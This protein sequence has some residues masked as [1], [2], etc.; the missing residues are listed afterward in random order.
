ML[1]ELADKRKRY[2]EIFLKSRQDGNKTQEFMA[3]ALGVSRNTIKN[4]ERGTSFPNAFQEELWFEALGLNIDPYKFAYQY[5]ELTDKEYK[6]SKEFVEKLFWKL[7]NFFTEKDR[8]DLCFLVYGEH[9]SDWHSVLQMIT[10]HLQCPMS[11]RTIHANTITNNYELSE[12][13]GELSCPD[14]VKPNMDLLKESIKKGTDAAVNNQR[15]YIAK[16]PKVDE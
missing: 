8:R 6:Y 7:P 13:R 10:A 16:T 11:Y 3:Q 4:W 12:R 14:N 2:G 15:G 5:P 9:G 1:D